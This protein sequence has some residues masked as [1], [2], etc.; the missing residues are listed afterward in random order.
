MFHHF[1]EELGR[2]DCLVFSTTLVYGGDPI[3]SYVT[4]AVRYARGTSRPLEPGR[5]TH[6]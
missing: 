3:A 6:M 5:R 4:K 1:P 2:L